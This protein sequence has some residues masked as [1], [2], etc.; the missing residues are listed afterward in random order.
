M[1]LV[2]F[3][4]Q[5][6]AE[7]DRLYRAISHQ[8]PLH[9]TFKGQALQ[10]FDVQ[11]MT[12]ACSQLEAESAGHFVYDTALKSILVKCKADSFLS[13]REV[14]Y[15]TKKMSAEAFVNGQKLRRSTGIFM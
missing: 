14:R 13:I 7:I 15:G 8:Y 6:A 5:T 9:T 2:N 4:E 12:N 1:S 10:L 11:V 3:S